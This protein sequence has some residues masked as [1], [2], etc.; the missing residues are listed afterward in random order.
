[1][2]RSPMTW[3]AGGVAAAGVAALAYLKL[4]RPWHL[5]WGATGEEGTR[6]M[7]GDGLV[8]EPQYVTTRAITIQARPEQIWPWLVQMGE[9][10]GGF[11]SY[12]WIERLLGMRLEN[13]DRILPEFQRLKVGDP[14]AVEPQDDYV[15]QVKLLEPQRALVLGGSTPAP[16]GEATWSMALYPLDAHSTRLVSRCRTRFNSTRN[17]LL[18]LSFLDIGQLIMERKWLLGVKERAERWAHPLSA[19]LPPSE[20]HASP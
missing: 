17:M 19:P 12:V 6:A 3:V 1:M 9:G 10:R 18:I 16:W 8:R 13:A 20:L 11:Y 2:R 5:R 15:M 7:P 14:L 4:L